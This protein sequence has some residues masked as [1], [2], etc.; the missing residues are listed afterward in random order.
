MIDIN[1]TKW[2]KLYIT[3]R[4]KIVRYKNY[5]SNTIPVISGVPQGSH[6]GPA[7]AHIFINNITLSIKFSNPLLY[8]DDFR[9]FGI[10]RQSGQLDASNGFVL[11]FWV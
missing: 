7:M 8:A 3:G 11:D 2:I 5:Y 9:I 10:I 4:T 6:L 1:L